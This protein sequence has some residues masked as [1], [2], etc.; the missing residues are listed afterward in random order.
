MGTACRPFISHNFDLDQGGRWP[1]RRRCWRNEWVGYSRNRATEF[2]RKHR[3]DR[4]TDRAAGTTRTRVADDRGDGALL[5]PGS[6]SARRGYLS[7]MPRL[8]GLRGAATGPMPIRGGKAHVCEVSRSLLSKSAP[9]TGASDHA[10]R[11]TADA[12]AASHSQSAALDGQ[13]SPGTLKV[14]DLCHR[15]ADIPVSSNVAWQARPNSMCR[16]LRPLLRTGMPARR[17]VDFVAG[18][19]FTAGR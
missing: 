8:A 10:L 19:L 12:L 17:P 9:G 13:F 16:V 18:S 7:G 11:G 15:R 5:L 2:E 4:S 6:S 1:Y 3:R 14:R